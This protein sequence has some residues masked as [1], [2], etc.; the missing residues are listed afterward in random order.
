MRGW[1]AITNR[2]LLPQL[3]VISTH[4]VLL[5]R[6]PLVAFTQSL[7]R[8]SAPF[9]R[10]C[11]SALW[12]RRQYGWK[13]DQRGIEGGLGRKDGDSSQ[14]GQRGMPRD[15]PKFSSTLWK[16]DSPA[17]QGL[18]WSCRWFGRFGVGLGS[19]WWCSLRGPSLTIARRLVWCVQVI[20]DF[21]A[22]WCGPCHFI[23]P[24][25]E[26]LSKNHP[27]I[28]FLKVDVDAAQVSVTQPEPPPAV[29][30]DDGALEHCAGA[31]VFAF[32][33]GGRRFS[34]FRVGSVGGNARL[35]LILK[36]PADNRTCWKPPSWNEL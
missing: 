30:P 13:R 5:C 3:M 7:R 23:A 10:F 32:Q 8:T 20:V 17:D 33:P 21:F 9:V 27:D 29:R 18:E 31:L 6:F 19:V 25:V 24:T 22:T 16:A 34:Q 14:R 12:V 26:A 11:F 1:S 2:L 35:V 4:A 36:L 15:W 28:M